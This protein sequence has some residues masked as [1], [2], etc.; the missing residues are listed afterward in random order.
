MSDKHMYDILGK[1]NNLDPQLAAVDSTE[2]VTE[3]VDPNSLKG[4]IQQLEE[5]YMGWKKTVAAIK[6]SGS[7]ED[8]EAVAAA[9]G[10]NKYGKEKF[11]K[12]AA[13]GKKLGEEAKPDFLDLDN[14][15]NKQEPMKKAARDKKAVAEAREF[16][17]KDEFDNRAQ[18]GDYYYTKAGHKVTKTA[19]GIKHE[20]GHKQDRDNE[21]AL[22]E[23]QMK[24][25][26]HAAAEKMS[27]KAFLAKHC[28]RDEDRKEMTDF[29][30]NVHGEDNLQE[31]AKSKAQQ[32]FMGMVYAAKK[33]EKPASKAVAKAAADMSKK[34]A[35][36]YAATKHKGLP[37]KVDEAGKLNPEKGDWNVFDT[38]T[39]K[40][41]STHSSYGKAQNAMKKLNKEHDGYEMP[42]GT[43]KHKFGMKSA[44]LKESHDIRKH[45]I[46]TTQ[47]AW[48]HYA[49]EL[50]EHERADQAAEAMMDE[51]SNMHPSMELDEIARLAGL[52]QRLPAPGEPGGPPAEITLDPSQMAP[53]SKMPAKLPP[54]TAHDPKLPNAYIEEAQCMECGMW[55]SQC[56]CDYQAMDE[57][58]AD[59]KSK[60]NFADIL[61]TAIDRRNAA[62][63]STRKEIGSRVDDIGSGSQQHTDRTDAAGDR[64][65]TV[66][67][68]INMNISAN[69]PEDVLNVIQKLAGMPMMAVV[70]DEL[71]P[72]ADL[73]E[74]VI[75]ERPVEYTNSPREMTAPPEAA[76]PGGTDLN[77][78]KKQ[79]RREY[80]GDN[81]MAVQEQK[82]WQQYQGMIKGLKD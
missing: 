75:N 66:K 76:V 71:S 36:D 18:V 69:G 42:G 28:H 53:P 21:D 2:S 79:Y 9:I 54:D 63:V 5:K 81:P 49:E 78:P 12:A 62:T 22:Q 13:A 14:D 38:K 74:E 72:N 80:P 57:S 20:R 24:H 25:M 65:Q 11:Q 39:K 6:K 77:R 23:G 61:K 4:H 52:P 64:E 10:R 26:L 55:E 82:L 51:T 19:S 47:E 27:L 70:T 35:K 50:A 40:V 68:D 58:I 31:R 33:G 46:Y 30:K 7:A 44:S 67:E 29:W 16:K 56:G 43:V 17:N 73:E 34:A 1:F 48:D 60:P 15:G 32:K 8:P 59:R 37:Q 3:A 45:P 41:H